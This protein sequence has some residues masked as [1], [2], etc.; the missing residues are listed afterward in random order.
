MANLPSRLSLSWDS[1]WHDLEAA[2]P[3]PGRTE[4]VMALLEELSRHADQFRAVWH[5]LGFIYV[6][7]LRTAKSTLRLH[8]WLGS[9]RRRTPSQLLVHAHTWHLTSHVIA[10]VLDNSIIQVVSDTTSPTHRLFQIEGSTE[11]DWIQPTSE[12]VAYQVI[13]TERVGKG[14]RYTIEPGEFHFTEVP[15]GV[16]TSTIVLAVRHPGLTE[17][18]LGEPHVPEHRVSRERCTPDEVTDAAREVALELIGRTSGQR[19]LGSGPFKDAA[20]RREF[21]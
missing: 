18:A 15:E 12:L 9:S 7:L 6:E 11:E 21:S 20:A 1:F 5:P 16:L 4:R 10:G 19:P 3:E 17:R 2:P 14:N 13:S 8:I